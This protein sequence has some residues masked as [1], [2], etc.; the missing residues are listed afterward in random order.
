MEARRAARDGRRIGRSD[1]LGERLLE[2]VDG[3]AER[4]PPGAEHVGDELLL[5]FV[6]PGRGEADRPDGRHRAY[7][8]EG[9][10]ST[11]SR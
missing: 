1:G 4:E 11:T 9:V 6:E 7:A 3:R 2:S 10:S 8:T 5:P